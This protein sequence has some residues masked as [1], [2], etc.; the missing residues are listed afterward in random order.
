MDPAYFVKFSSRFALKPIKDGKATTVAMTLSS[1]NF[2]TNRAIE[3]YSN[4]IRM[5]FW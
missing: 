4:H 2:P 3:S 1:H 5:P